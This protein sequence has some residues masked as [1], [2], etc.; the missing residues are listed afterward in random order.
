MDATRRTSV[1]RLLARV[2]ADRREPAPNEPVAPQ[3][4]AI[5]YVCGEP[6]EHTAA[7]RSCCEARG[8]VLTT[9]V[10][11]LDPDGDDNRPSLAWA[12]AQL[13][14]QHAEALV[15]ARLRDLSANVANLPPLLTWFNQER[16]ILIALDRSLD[17]STTPGRRA[18]AAIAGAGVWSVSDIPELQRRIATMRER[19]MSLQAIADSL[20][21][22]GVPTLRGGALWRPSSVQRATGYR[23]PSSRR[24]FTPR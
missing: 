19:G 23:R 8:L 14:D 22:E 13:A 16:R 10:H 7:I 4:R 3:R 11:D 17:T 18:A 20:N 21:D 15:L 6:R 24:G 2:R 5:G 9:I 1:A 12:L